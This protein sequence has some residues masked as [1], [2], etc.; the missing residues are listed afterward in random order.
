MNSTFGMWRRSLSQL[1]TM[2][3]KK[4][5]DALDILSKWF[6]ATRSVV[7]PSSHLSGGNL[8]GNTCYSST[9][10]KRSILLEDAG[11]TTF[12][13]FYLSARCSGSIL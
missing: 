7:V 2:K 8:F 4:E 13:T 11:R 3:E 9:T 6:I 5:W 1:I 12:I 10:E